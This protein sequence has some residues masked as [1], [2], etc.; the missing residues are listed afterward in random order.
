MT[1][2]IEVTNHESH[3]KTTRAIIASFVALVIFG[4]MP[5]LI[6]WSENEISPNATMF[7]RCWIAAI[8]FGIWQELLVYTGDRNRYCTSA[9]NRCYP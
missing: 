2:Q 7:N 6:R 4:I 1:D 8:I 3:N 5:I 9:S